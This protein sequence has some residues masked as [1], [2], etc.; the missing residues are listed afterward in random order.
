MIDFHSHVLPQMDDGP[1][2]LRESLEMLSLCFRQGVDAVVSTSHFYAYQEDPEAFLLRRGQR[3][4]ALRE[5]M[6]CSTEVYPRIIPG[7]EVL[8]FPGIS[9]AQE[10]A[11]LSIA[12]RAILIEPPM[13]PWSEDMLDEI[14]RL[15]EN[16]GLEPVVAHVD[17]YMLML[18]DNRLIDRVLERGL[19]V[20]VNGSY[21]LDEK[22]EKAAVRNLR[23]GRI[24]L[25]GSDCHNLFD[26]APNL[27]PV[28]RAVRA[29]GA[30]AE[31][32]TL[33]EN[34]AGLLGLE[35]ELL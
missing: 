12:G 6:L 7:A 25:I 1:E 8:Y 30:E 18:G 23:R 10:V 34:A 35:G 32:R 31:F 11:E 16:F 19:L 13:A 26:R 4:R 2:S 20:Q 24:H 15:G 5:A 22:R 21:F 14:V 17:R 29:A 28:R 33:Q 3:L 9:Q 27:G